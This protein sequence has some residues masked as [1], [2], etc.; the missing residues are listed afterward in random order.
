MFAIEFYERHIKARRV[1]IYMRIMC[2]LL[3]EIQLSFL[4]YL[5]IVIRYD[6]ACQNQMTNDSST[7][8]DRW[9]L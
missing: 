7:V 9:Q 1:P 6:F 5:S 3:S 2:Y 8:S 4:G